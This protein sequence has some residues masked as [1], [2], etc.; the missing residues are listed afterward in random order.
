MT[1]LGTST[2]CARNTAKSLAW[3]ASSGPFLSCNTTAAERVKRAEIRSLPG[4]AAAPCNMH[5]T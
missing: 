5:A 1:D 2:V 4:R 3:A